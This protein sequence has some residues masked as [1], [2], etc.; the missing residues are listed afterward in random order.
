MS[1]LSLPLFHDE[2]TA[3]AKLESIIWP[4]GPVCVHCGET[5]RIGR[6]NGKSTKL[7]TWKCYTCKKKFSATVGTVFESSHIPVHQ[8]LQA[9]YLICISKKGFS[10]HQMMR[11]MDVQYKTAWFMT[12]RIKEAM[13]EGDR[14]TIGSL[15][16]EG[17]TVEADETWVGG[18]AANRAYGPIPPKQAVAALVERGGS[19]RFFHVPHV[20]AANLAP[21]IA[22]HAH[23]NS[24]FMTDESS[25]YSQAGTWFKDHQAVNHSIKEYVRD[26]AIPT[27]SKVRSP[28]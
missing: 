6:L 17:S 22:R 12:H 16:G 2:T 21:I 3:V 13:T 27:R 26:E 20:T 18:K 10:N 9:V 1:V 5:G 4:N 23:L 24:T 19:L 8:W 25:V 11:T 28:S 7:G 15:G 14:R